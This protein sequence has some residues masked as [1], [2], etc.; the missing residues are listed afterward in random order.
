MLMESFSTLSLTGTEQAD[1]AIL[2]LSRRLRSAD[3]DVR[4]T[5]EAELVDTV[6]RATSGLHALAAVTRT[7]V[8]P[9]GPRGGLW[10]NTGQPQEEF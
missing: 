1:V 2:L 7:P 9:L 8:G 3:A 6:A 10:N 4:R 5:A